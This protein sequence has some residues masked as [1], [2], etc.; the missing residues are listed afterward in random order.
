MKHLLVLAGLAVGSSVLFANSESGCADFS[1]I[2]KNGECKVV[3]GPSFKRADLELK[4]TD[5][6]AI[7]LG[8]RT[9]SIPGQA[10]LVE[11]LPDGGTFTLDVALEWKGA[12]QERLLLIQKYSTQGAKTPL[13]GKFHE[14]WSLDQGKLTAIY[15]GDV[16]MTCTFEK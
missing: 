16:A 10:T 8:G 12:Q 2:W 9:V 7:D 6:S 13:S 11:D 15:T 4:Q 14:E 1:G 3:D 5:C